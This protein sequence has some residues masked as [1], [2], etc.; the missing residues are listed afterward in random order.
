M[1]PN[2]TV[3]QQFSLNF[4]HLWEPKYSA[5][6][7]RA[8]LQGVFGNKLLKE[9]KCRLL[10]PAYDVVA[11][12]IFLFKTRH[13]PRFLFDENASAVEIALTTAAA[14]TFCCCDEGTESVSSSYRGD[15]TGISGP[16]IFCCYLRLAK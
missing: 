4:R 1:F 7:P 2:I 13:D 9:S 16:L 15:L 14:P 3:Q 6:P 10:I 5:E 11:G 8:A 12:R